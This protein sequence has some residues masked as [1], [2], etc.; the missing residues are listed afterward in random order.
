MISSVS[1]PDV[2]QNLG[3][4]QPGATGRFYKPNLDEAARAGRA[5]RLS[6]A[7]EQKERHLLVLVDFQ[8]DFVE[9]GSLPVA[10]ATHDLE[11]VIYRLVS[12]ILTGYYTDIIVTVDNHPPFT[13][14]SGLVYKDDKG[15]PPV[16]VAPDGSPLPMMVTLSKSKSFPLIGVNHLGEET[17][18]KPQVLRD[19]IINQYIPHLA[20]TGQSPLMIWPAHCRQD[21]LGASLNPALIEALEWASAARF[22]QPIRLYKGHIEETDWYGAFEPCMPVPNHPQGQLQ[23]RNMDLISQ[24]ETTEIAGEAL[25]FC[26]KATTLQ[27]LNYYGQNQTV[28][29]SIKFIQDGTSA[30]IPDGSVAGTTPN[31]DFIAEMVR[32]GVNLINSSDPF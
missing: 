5:L 10:G 11:R 14:H 28:L 13:V 19:H 1:W 24:V 3:F 6:P 30:I 8:N 23:T 17:P 15:K 26:V 32:M 22:I 7:S 16:L 31:A 18:L 29:R 27:V 21:N 9:G 25:D 12:G 20:S 4:A 2:V